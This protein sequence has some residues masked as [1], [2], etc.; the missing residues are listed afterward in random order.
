[1]TRPRTILLT[2]LVMLLA[3]RS[4]HGDDAEARAVKAIE[5]LGGKVTRERTVVGEFVIDAPACDG[6]SSDYDVS[7]IPPGVFPYPGTRT[8]TVVPRT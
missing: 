7:C 1:M 2:L 4:V 8:F 3:D 5:N 6:T